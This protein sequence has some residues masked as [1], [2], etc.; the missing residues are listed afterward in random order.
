MNLFTG[1]YGYE[2]V[3]LIC[4]F[5]L[6]VFA[7]A[8]ITVM[9]VQRR[10]FK[11]MIVLFLI[12]IVLM[13]FPGIAAVKFND[14]VLEVDTLR[15]QPA[16][17]LT[18]QQQ[19]QY[20]KTLAEVEQRSAGQPAL[21]AKVAD[22]YRVLGDVNRAYALAQSVLAQNPKPA[23]RQLLVPV[24]TAR[25]NQ[26]AQ[27]GAPSA[28]PPP[29]G[30]GAPAATP[31]V[32]PARQHEIATVAKQLQATGGALPATSH[33]ALARAYVALGQPQQ[34]AA[35]VTAARRL[36]PHIPINPALLQATRRPQ[37]NG[38]H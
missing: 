12:A 38:A 31:P 8:A 21:Q 34:A 1:L 4:G 32:A 3:M 27:V 29:A 9:I 6:F 25:L 20:A 37:S 7:M 26:V 16:G 13:G 24:L 2:C 14:G 22:G 11:A 23:T 36:D 19:Q 18:P 5:V 35:N 10:S 17:S 15:Q 28:T 30:S 33:V